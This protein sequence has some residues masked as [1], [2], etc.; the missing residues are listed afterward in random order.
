MV[1][2]VKTRTLKTLDKVG[3]Q[4]S[5]ELKRD[6]NDALPNF[7]EPFLEAANLKHV[8]SACK[9]SISQGRY[10]WRHT[11][12]KCLASTVKNERL[13]QHSSYLNWNNYHSLCTQGPDSNTLGKMVMVK[14]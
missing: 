6:V 9:T 10:T 5:K 13:K 4:K 2:V 12:V 14:W 1:S 11:H 8:L 3:N 7:Q